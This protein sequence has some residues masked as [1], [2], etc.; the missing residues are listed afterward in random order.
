MK[1]CIQ[2]SLLLFVI[3]LSIP[4]VFAASPDNIWNEVSDFYL[5][6]TSSQRT[7]VPDYYRT[8]RLN[9]DALRSVLRN[10]PMEYTDEARNNP[11][12][13]T[14]PM[15]DGSFARFSF[16][17]SPVIEPGLAVKYPELNETFRGQGIDD[18]TATARFD[19]LPSGFHSMIL[20]ANGTVMVDP[21]AKDDTDNYIAYFKKAAPKTSNFFCQ[22]EDEDAFQRMSRARSFDPN[23]FVAEPDGSA[24]VVSGSE[25]RTYRLA[26][27]ATGEY[28]QAVGGGT[29]AGALAAQVLIMNRVNGVYER[30]VAI[31]MNII[32]NNDLIIYTNG[33]TDPY[34]NNDGVAMLSQ[35][36]TNLNSVIGTANYDIGH[37]FSTGGGGV[38]TLNGPCGGNKARGVT[39]LGNPVGDPFAIDYVAHEMGH[40]WGANHTFNS[41]VG[42]CGGGNRSASS[43]YEPGSGI[44]IMAY[45]GIC[46]NQ[47][48]ARHSIDSFHV[49]SLEAI[50]NFSQNGNGNSCAVT[51]SSGNTPPVVNPSGLA[52]YDVP[53]QTPFVLNAIGT[54]ADSDTLTYDWQEYDL[55]GST[56]AVPNTDSDGTAR[57]ILRP[58]SPVSEPYRYFPSL[59]YILA[60]ANVPPATSP[61]VGGGTCLTG[62]LL[63]AITRTMKFQVVARD[64]NPNGGGINTATVTLNIDGNS[65]PFEITA[66]NGGGSMNSGT[67]QTVTWNVNG[68]NASPVNA[69]NV[70]IMMSTDGGQT[71]PIVLSSSTPNDGSFDF[72]V[73]AVSTD[74]ARIV[75]AA[76]GN[77]FFDISNGSFSVVNV[78]ASSGTLTGRIV[79]SLGNPI[80]GVG[81]S[82]SGSSFR[83]STVTNTFGYFQFSLVPTGQNYT[84][85]PISRRGITF[86]PSSIS[87]DF[88]G[89]GA[90]LAFTGTDSN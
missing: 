81:V 53:K 36:T 83:R 63:P 7:V 26:L 22:F 50:V 5:R 69:A 35:N 14:L 51:T 49:K 32:A 64:N 70:A 77:V 38:A 40:Q 55:G 3:A 18:P 10:A 37:V 24:N 56:T 44:T 52:T 76:V 23:S 86:S 46:S 6:A 66:P 11:T 31:H 89:Q 39:G 4:S 62:E 12:I 60:N 90:P 9:K 80:R 8:F 28:S 33:S 75:V 73:P 27:A 16:T 54:D 43:A 34:T 87:V 67:T 59:Q 58:Y 61:C 88:D 84:V 45:A 85:T 41:T 78:P 1:K 30:D 19:F 65:G 74:Q 82:L 48:L 57:P 21:Y 15:P 71:F 29:V 72:T 42:N 13:I 79:D 20:S 2:F 17:R 68:T 47:D 25:M